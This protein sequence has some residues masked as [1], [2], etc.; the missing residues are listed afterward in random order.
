DLAKTMLGGVRLADRSDHK[1]FF[2]APGAASDYARIFKTAQEMYREEGVLK[3]AA[4]DP[5]GSVNR[6]LVTS[7]AR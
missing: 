2:G 6:N 4:S 5:E 3:G 7:I 1:A